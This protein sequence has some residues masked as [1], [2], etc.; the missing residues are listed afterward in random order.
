MQTAGDSTRGGPSKTAPSTGG[1]TLGRNSEGRAHSL[2]CIMPRV[3][4]CQEFAGLL[5]PTHEWTTSNVGKMRTTLGRDRVVS[6]TAMPKKK[7]AGGPVDPIIRRN[8]QRRS[9]HR[10]IASFAPATGGRMHMGATNV[11]EK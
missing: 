7:T 9:T 8:R 2:G 5:D 6:A 4:P 10:R 3:H 1:G 11:P